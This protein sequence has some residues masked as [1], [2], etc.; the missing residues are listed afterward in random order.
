MMVNFRFLRLNVTD[1]RC[2]LDLIQEKAKQYKLSN[3]YCN[4][5]RFK[6]QSVSE[7]IE[8]SAVSIVQQASN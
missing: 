5:L 4:Q 3:F 8:T 2:K 7:I 6:P 1:R